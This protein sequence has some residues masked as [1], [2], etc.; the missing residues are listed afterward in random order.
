MR[1]ERSALY[2]KE[3]NFSL[4]AMRWG[5]DFEFDLST[6]DPIIHGIRFVTHF[7]TMRDTAD[8]EAK[9]LHHDLAEVPGKLILVGHSLGA[10]LV[11]H[12][13]KHGH[14]NLKKRVVGSIMFA[15]AVCE[16]DVMIRSQ[17]KRSLVCH[18]SYDS[19]LKYVYYTSELENAIGYHG[20]HSKNFD[21]LDLSDLEL[22]HGDYA[23][24]AYDILRRPEVVRH[25][26]SR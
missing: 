25:L 10:R 1:F 5:C 23:R 8:Q 18:S 14:T 24:H 13:L 17:W 4:Y 21:S 20:P 2:A 9:R 7:K 19:V 6:F 12:A 11:M 3:N 15:P 26:K 16:D 22:R